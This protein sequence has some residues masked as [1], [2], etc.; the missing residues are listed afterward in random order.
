MSIRSVIYRSIDAED[1]DSPIFTPAFGVE[2]MWGNLG[3]SVKE[4]QQPS[5]RNGSRYM[6]NHIASTTEY[7][8]D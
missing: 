6:L 2:L 8:P 1:G 4:R 5:T 3:I 7:V